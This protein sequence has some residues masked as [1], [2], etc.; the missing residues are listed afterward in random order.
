[1][2]TQFDITVSNPHLTFTIGRNGC[3][4]TQ[5]VNVCGGS[6]TVVLTPIGK[7]GL[8]RAGFS[9]PTEDMDRL[10]TTWLKERGKL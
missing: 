4:R 3:W 5:G 9:I 2:N 6:T 8:L 7:R 10:C 1:M